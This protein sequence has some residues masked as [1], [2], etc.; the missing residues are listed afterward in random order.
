MHWTSD[1]KFRAIRASL[2]RPSDAQRQAALLS[3]E[4]PPTARS[5]SAV[6]RFIITVL[7]AS[8]KQ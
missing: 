5:N 7:I 1:G 4:N 6:K 8:A 3:R 2:A